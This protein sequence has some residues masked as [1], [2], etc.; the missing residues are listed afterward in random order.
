MARRDRQ[1]E[2]NTILHIPSSLKAAQQ[3]KTQLDSDPT[4]Y[5]GSGKGFM[6]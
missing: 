3:L 6:K 4:I 1:R 5:G 2:D